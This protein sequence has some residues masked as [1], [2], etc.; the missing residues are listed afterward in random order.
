MSQLFFVDYRKFVFVRITGI[1]SSDAKKLSLMSE[2]PF[3]PV[4]VEVTDYSLAFG[5]E[6]SESFEAITFLNFSS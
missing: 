5:F 3:K 4:I 6:R 1:T 2:L